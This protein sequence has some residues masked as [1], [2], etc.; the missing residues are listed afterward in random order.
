[1]PYN[2]SLG[3]FRLLIAFGLLASVVWQVSDRIANDVFRPAEYFSYF[4]IVTALIAGFA[5]LLHGLALLMRLDDG[6]W[7]E[8]IRL[9][10]TVAIIVVG[11]VYHLL[12]ADAVADLRDGDYAWPVLPNE[13]IHSYAPILMVVDYLISQRAYQIRLRAFLWAL[14]LPLGWLLFTVVRGIA[15]D[16]WPYWFLDPGSEIGVSGMLLYVLGI[17]VLFLLLGLAVLAAKIAIRKLLK[18]TN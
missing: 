7:V 6:K 14:V 10:L 13:I 18:S 17:S 8:I 1:M 4:S 16:W 15:T 5:L 3:L 9:S 11:S 12:L 2:L